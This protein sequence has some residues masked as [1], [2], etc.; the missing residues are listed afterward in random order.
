MRLKVAVLV[1]VTL[2][3]QR[4]LGMPGMHDTTPFK[5]FSIL[6]LLGLCA[7]TLLFFSASRG[8]SCSAQ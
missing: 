3:V 2:I 4:V 5:A 8:I 7:T 6:C 1:A